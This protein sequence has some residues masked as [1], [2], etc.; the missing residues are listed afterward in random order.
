MNSK[1]T[2]F[3]RIF[4]GSVL[5]IFGANKIYA[6][7]PMPQSSQASNLLDSMADTGYILTFIALV[8]IIMGLLLLLK[9]WVPF[10][11]LLLAPWSLNILMFHLFLDVPM[12]SVAL[13]VVLLNAVLLY[14]YRHQYAPLFV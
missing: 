14:K 8:E 13:V 1:F 4:L 7:I 5:I 3:I 12:V 10:V 2:Q 11:L 6:F 9:L